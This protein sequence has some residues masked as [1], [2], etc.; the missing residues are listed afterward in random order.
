MSYQEVYEGWK[1]DPEAFWMEAARAIDWVKPPSHA[2]EASRAPLYGWYDDAVCNV[3]WNAV[4][5]H[6]EAG[7]GD[8]TAIIYDS[9]ITGTK[10]RTSFAELQAKA[11]ALGG[12][13]QAQGVGK[14]DRVVIYMPMI[15]EA[16]VAMLACARIGAVHSVVFGGFAPRTR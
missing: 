5:R 2:L 16:L 10:G 11:A 13:L 1:A 7:H 8:R 15:P 12:A 14:G 4:D 6:V 9:P 3:C